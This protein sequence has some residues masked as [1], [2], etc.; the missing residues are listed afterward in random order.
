MDNVSM[1]VYLGTYL[2]DIFK[3]D[4]TM[5][6]HLEMSFKYIFGRTMLQW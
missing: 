5:A 3:D 2:K 6:V 1:A 4:A